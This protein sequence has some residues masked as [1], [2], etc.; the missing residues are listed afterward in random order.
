[1]SVLQI[2]NRDGALWVTLNRP[3]LFNS[4]SPESICGMMDM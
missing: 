4:L 2:E 1:M 3:E